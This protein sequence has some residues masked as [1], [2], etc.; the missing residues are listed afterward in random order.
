[1]KFTIFTKLFLAVFLSLML[2]LAAMTASVQWAFRQDFSEYL[3][4]VEQARLLGLARTL[5]QAYSE[6]GNWDFL[7]GNQGYWLG[8]L[9]QAQA[10]LPDGPAEAW[11]GAFDP[12]PRPHSHPHPHPRRPLPDAPEAFGPEPPLPGHGPPH[13]GEPPHPRHDHELFRNGDLRV[14]DTDR[15]MLVG[16]PFSPPPHGKEDLYPIVHQGQTVGWLGFM[17]RPFKVD[18][19]EAA[20]IQQ[21]AKANWVILGLVL[22]VS[23]LVSLVLARQFLLP[24]RRLAQGAQALAQGRYAVRIPVSS[25]DELGQLARDFNRLAQ[26][27][28]RHEQARRQWVADTSHELRTPLAVLRSEIEALMDGIREPN[29]ERLRSLHSEVLG[30]GKL[31]DDLHALSL[32]DLGALNCRMDTLDLGEL[33]AGVAKGFES[34]FAAK[35]IALCPPAEDAAPLLVLGDAGRLRQLF[36]NLLENSLRYTDPAGR[37]ELGL[38]REDGK[39]VVLVEDSSPGVD[40]EALGRLFERFYRADQSRSRALGGTGLGLAIGLSI[41]E[42]HGGTLEAGHSRLG[43]LRLRVVLPALSS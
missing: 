40:D 37:C 6:H 35:G 15:S 12:P 19:L 30:L 10:L 34:R 7:R 13:P 25:R 26:A 9:R 38:C 22:G 36:M 27:L 18:R 21:H 16:P 17:P 43:G 2:I 5:G 33:L 3:R 14:L 23:L 39:A 24:V 4:N 29:P 20:F 31:V 32:S 41:A 42:A 28:E 1:M 8:L 11:P